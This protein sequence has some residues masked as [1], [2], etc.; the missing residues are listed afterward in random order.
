M[1]AKNT[2]QP[3]IFGHESLWYPDFILRGCF[4]DLEELVVIWRRIVV[5]ILGCPGFPCAH[6]GERVQDGSAVSIFVTASSLTTMADL[7]SLNPGAL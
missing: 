7:P 3:W 5:A 4:F 6:G 1:N 2:D